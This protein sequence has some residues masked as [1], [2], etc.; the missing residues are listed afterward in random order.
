[1]SEIKIEEDEK[2]PLSEEED[3]ESDIHNEIK[4]ESS[5]SKEAKNLNN[6]E[7]KSNY[8]NNNS[9]I[10]EVFKDNLNVEMKNL[11]SLLN[12]Y[13]YIGMDTEFPGIVY[14]FSSNEE[15]FYYKSLKINTESLKLIQLGITLSNSKGEN[16]R[17]YH[18]WQFNFEFDYLKDKYSEPSLK[19]LMSSGINFNKLKENG[20]N[21]KKFFQILKNSGLVLNPKIHW[22]SFHGNYDFAYLLY[23]LLG[24]SL[25]KSEEDFTQ[26]LRAFFPNYY[27]IKILVKEKYNMQG[28]LNKLAECLNIMREGKIHQAGSDSF[29]T[30]KVFWKL[31]KCG[32]IS[33]EEL[34]ENKNIIF[35]ILQGKDNETTMNYSNNF[36]KNNN[37]NNINNSVVQKYNEHNSIY[38]PYVYNMNMNYYYPQFMMNGLNYI[39][40]INNKSNLVQY[41]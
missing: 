27:D 22:V 17:P 30:I 16:P 12:E 26:L 6:E 25:P 14:S 32:Y 36:I 13:N 35:G 29:V 4:K 38:L 3:N 34:M 11:I 24:S 8:P 18:T 7:N 5:H 10:I 23:N 33:R 37:I 31:I 2:P 15:D 1:M 20:I 39:Q 19:L 9:G 41:C 21:H 40:M 28:S